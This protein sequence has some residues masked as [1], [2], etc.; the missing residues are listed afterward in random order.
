MRASSFFAVSLLLTGLSA[1]AAE[2]VSGSPPPS[3]AAPVPRSTDVDVTSTSNSRDVP[4]DP[5]VST[6]PPLQ[7]A[8]PIVDVSATV[9]TGGTGGAPTVS[10]SP[11][12]STTTITTI[13]PG[14]ADAVPETTRLR[15]KNRVNQTLA[16]GDQANTR[17]DIYTTSAIRQAL[18]KGKLSTNARNIKI[19]TTNGR[20]TLTGPVKTQAEKAKIESI[21]RVAAGAVT[22]DSQLDVQATTY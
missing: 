2:L 19:V 21:A 14:G 17:A 11:G 1:H 12:A 18:L 4:V 15:Q 9:T 13:T 3:G 7:S 10:G 8:A 22:V 5:G 16:P 6:P 20:V